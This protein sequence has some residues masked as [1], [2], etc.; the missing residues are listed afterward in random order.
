MWTFMFF[1]LHT[2]IKILKSACTLCFFKSLYIFKV[3]E[4]MWSDG[5]VNQ[6]NCGDHFTMYQ[7]VYLKYIQF[8]FVN[9]SLVKLKKNCGRGRV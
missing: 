6:L 4:A 5:Y 8:L 3:I 9:Y 1:D 7:F 2:C